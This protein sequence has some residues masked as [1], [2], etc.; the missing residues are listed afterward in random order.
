MV[1][2]WCGFFQLGMFAR[3]NITTLMKKLDHT[4]I[5]VGI[6]LVWILATVGYI[7]T[8]DIGPWSAF[9]LVYKF[10]SIIAVF[11]MVDTCFK[12]VNILIDIGKNTYLIYFL[13]MQFGIFTIRYIF[14]KI[15]ILHLEWITLIL[16]PVCI[17]M[18]VYAG[19]KLLRFLSQKICLDRFMWVFGI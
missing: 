9:A 15:G 1:L 4:I 8:N 11:I 16:Q 2:N 7:A 14:Q 18:V 6:V 12:N 3:K 19:I 13:H 10:I 17:L 5:K